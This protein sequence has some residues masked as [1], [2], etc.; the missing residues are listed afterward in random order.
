MAGDLYF[1]LLKYSSYRVEKNINYHQD[2][3]SQ[4]RTKALN[5]TNTG[6]RVDNRRL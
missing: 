6:D 5:L 3:V 4:L 1:I 2:N